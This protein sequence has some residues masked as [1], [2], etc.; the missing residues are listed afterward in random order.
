[1]R[2]QRHDQRDPSDRDR[3]AD[4]GGQIAAGGPTDLP[5][6]PDA[7]DAVDA[8][9]A[10][11]ALAE[12]TRR[13]LHTWVAAQ[14]RAVG[15]DEAAAA[16]GIERALAAHHLDRLVTAR[17]L[18]PEYR[19]LS[20]RTG[21]GAGR[22][23]KLYR[24]APGTVEVSVPTRRYELAARLLA[25][26]HDDRFGGEDSAS[27]VLSDEA[28]DALPHGVRS[29]GER[30]G[31]S[32]GRFARRRAGRRPSRTSLR[33]ALVDV[34]NESG[35]APVELDGAIRFANCPFD[36]LVADHRDLVCGMNLTVADGIVEELAG[37]R[38]S[39][40]LEPRPGWC[41]VAIRE[42]ATA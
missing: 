14:G 40:T 23:A 28:V 16:V 30:H 12:P 35:Y 32:L 20:G 17:L 21:P 31:R 2:H 4:A 3:T 18:V 41:C 7:T 22:P 34:L 11:A 36:A 26:G 24:P 19:R 1:M 6:G 13:Q 25:A 10:I 33:A 37:D 38:L 5:V 8:I 39:A 27:G 42:R 9:D 29:A 15:R